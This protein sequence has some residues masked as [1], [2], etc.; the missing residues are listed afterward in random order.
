MHE[1]NFI[2][3]EPL[4]DPKQRVIGYELSWHL[5]PNQVV[6]DDDLESLIGFVAENV[7][8][9]LDQLGVPKPHSVPDA[10][11]PDPLMDHIALEDVTMELVNLTGHRFNA[12]QVQL[13]I[14]G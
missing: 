8:D 4:L 7:N 9:V 10:N 1:T 12:P 14:G 2:V 3:R 5:E 13:H 6:T 11:I